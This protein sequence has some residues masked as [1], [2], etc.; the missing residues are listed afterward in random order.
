MVVLHGFEFAPE[1]AP[2]HLGV[3]LELLMRWACWDPSRV[4]S[5]DLQ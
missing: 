4:A 5:P 1:V 3:G 2:Q